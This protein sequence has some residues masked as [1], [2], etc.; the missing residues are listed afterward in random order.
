MR[1]TLPP[2]TA[3]SARQKVQAAEDGWNSR[4]PQKVAL[5]YTEDTVWRNRDHFING[6]AEVE[7]FLAGK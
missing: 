7:A 6:R 5:A 4:N 1:P 2:F 3:E